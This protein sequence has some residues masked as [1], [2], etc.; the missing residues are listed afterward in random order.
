MNKITDI[1]GKIN[2]Q[3]EEQARKDWKEAL[4]KASKLIEPFVVP[5]NDTRGAV[6]KILKEIGE[7]SIYASNNYGVILGYEMKVPESYV[8]FKQDKASEEFIKKVN[9]LQDQIDELNGIVQ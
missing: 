4:Q 7:K 2:E 6:E 8:K 3:A 9:G 1:Q 5:G